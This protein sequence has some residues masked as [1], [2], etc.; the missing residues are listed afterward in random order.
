MQTCGIS[1]FN[2]QGWVCM[3]IL[4]LLNWKNIGKITPK[5][6]KIFFCWLILFG[7]IMMAKGM[8]ENLLWVIYMI[9][10]FFGTLLFLLNYTDKKL[11][12]ID[13]LYSFLKILFY[14]SLLHILVLILF[15]SYLIN[16]S[17]PMNPKTFLYLFYYNYQIGIPP[18][19][20]RVQ[21]IAWEPGNWQ[22][23]LNLFLFFSILKKQKIMLLV[24]C[25][26][27]ILSTFSTNGYILLVV[28]AIIYL[29]LSTKLKKSLPIVII[30]GAFIYPIVSHNITE[31]L[32]GD[33]LI[34]GLARMR[35][36]EVG[37]EMMFEHPWIGVDINKL[38]E[39]DAV[40]KMKTSLFN[41]RVDLSSHGGYD[42]FM[43]DG[44]LNGFLGVFLDWGVFLGLALY[45]L[46]YKSPLL[47][48]KKIAIPFCLICFLSFSA[49]PI[50]RT[51][52]FYLFPLSALFLDTT[53]RKKKVN[54]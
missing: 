34:S 32:S 42:G 52:F 21:G 16:T 15:H 19:F 31:K 35:D 10:V 22:L 41:E 53:N 46:F 45:F 5:R 1:L 36:L 51:S 11:S 30:L 43:N 25:G 49:E 27:T 38:N 40:K 8:F 17:L 6:L 48:N 50:T 2:G 54:Q 24:F 3:V 39:I 12:F 18:Y 33:K 14:Y 29:F 13:D 7:G 20:Y 28:N 23:F 44:Y 9:F 26:I 37:K 47:E 4:I